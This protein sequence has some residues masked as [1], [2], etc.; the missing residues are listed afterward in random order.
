[1]KRTLL[2]IAILCVC[3]LT[4][5]YSPEPPSTQLCQPGDLVAASKFDRPESFGPK[6]RPGAEGCAR[7]LAS[8]VSLT[9]LPLP[10]KK[11][12]ARSVPTGTKPFANMSP[13]SVTL[14]SAASSSWDHPRRSALFVAIR[15]RRINTLGEWSSRPRPSGFKK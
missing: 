12:Q 11:V 15:I 7:A 1:M 9:A 14:Y 8:G 4:F 5:A 3:R 13:T 6:G 2:L 10:R